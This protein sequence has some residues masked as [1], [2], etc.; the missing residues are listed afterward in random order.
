A[1]A[2]FPGASPPPSPEPPIG[3]RSA[4]VGRRSS[5]VSTSATAARQSS[6]QSVKRQQQE[7]RRELGK[8]ERALLRH[9]IAPPSDV[10]DILDPRRTQQK[11]SLRLAAVD[12]C[13]RLVAV[14]RV[15]HP[16]R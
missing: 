6:S 2:S 14:R 16:A 11:G 3:S 5:T 1:P 4:R 9:H 8:E 12:R 15:R 7:A 13:D 10:P